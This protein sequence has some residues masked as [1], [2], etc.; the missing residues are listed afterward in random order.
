[1]EE[2][3]FLIFTGLWGGVK[4][5]CS[6]MYIGDVGWLGDG[7]VLWGVELMWH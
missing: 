7:G 2:R 6:G 5:R 3:D 4:G 1:M